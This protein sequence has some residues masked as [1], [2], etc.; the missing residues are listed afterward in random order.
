MLTTRPYGARCA[1]GQRA[2]LAAIH[3][4]DRSL[5][6]DVLRR[7]AFMGK[8]VERFLL[9]LCELSLDIGG[10]GLKGVRHVALRKVML[11]I[12][13]E[14][15]ECRGHARIRRDDHDRKRS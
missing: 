15:A 14:A 2:P 11:H 3:H 6:N 13:Q 10:I 1:D 12:D 5:E 4:I 8:A 7:D 9:E